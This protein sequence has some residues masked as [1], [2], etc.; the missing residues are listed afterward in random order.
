MFHT[1]GVSVNQ[2]F[3]IVRKR[4]FDASHGFQRPWKRCREIGDLYFIPLD[5][6]PLPPDEDNDSDDIESPVEPPTVPTVSRAPIQSEF[7]GDILR[8]APVVAPELASRDADRRARDA[9]AALRQHHGD[10]MGVLAG[11]NHPNIPTALKRYG[12]ALGENYEVLNVVMLGM[13]G[14]RVM[15]MSGDVR[16]TL[17]D[18]VAADFEEFAAAHGIFIQRFP[19]WLA[20]LA[21]MAPGETNAE[22]AEASR[23][24]GREVTA[25]AERLPDYI[26]S[27]IPEALTGLESGLNDG[28][29]ADPVQA[30]GYYR[31]L[32]NVLVRVV[33]RTLLE[34][35][36]I[37]DRTGRRAA[38]VLKE[39]RPTA[40]KEAA[41]GVLM[42]GLTF[43]LETAQYLTGLSAKLPVLFDWLEAV[44]RWFRPW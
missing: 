28:G 4:V 15:R 24:D 27:R 21:D 35:R 31:S 41:K 38:E 32:R 36:A 22:G 29:S 18:I 34:L 17:S 37:A 30:A 25:V 14:R 12:E 2:I 23:S 8:P 9:W 10:L 16:D 6:V 43:I 26:D 19:E 3:D 5:T 13:T 44:V 1:P 11:C 33:D 39:L 42:A 40:N 7:D 20:Y